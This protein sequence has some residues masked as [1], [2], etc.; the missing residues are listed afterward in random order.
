[1][2]ELSTDEQ[3]RDSVVIK[4]DDVNNE[5]ISPVR[6]KKEGK[7]PE[8]VNVEDGTQAKTIP[9]KTD[10]K[11]KTFN[12]ATER[13][14]KPVENTAVEKKI[15]SS[16]PDKPANVSKDVE[17]AKEC[18]KSSVKS[19]SEQGMQVKNKTTTEKEA[20]C[21]VKKNLINVVDDAV[22][23]TVKN[24]STQKKVVSEKKGVTE[25]GEV[26]KL[27]VENIKPAGISAPSSETKLKLGKGS[28]T[29]KSAEPK[30]G[31]TSVMR[32]KPLIIG[33]ENDQA[34][35]EKSQ[36]TANI[37]HV[38][39]KV[40]QDL[41]DTE[42]EKKCAEN[43]FE[44]NKLDTAVDED[45]HSGNEKKS[46]FSLDH[47][48]GRLI[49]ELPGATAASPS[50][51][52][53]SIE[54]KN[55]NVEKSVRNAENKKTSA[56][57]STRAEMETEIGNDPAE[58][59]LGSTEVSGEPKVAGEGQELG[60]SVCAVGR[61]VTASSSRNAI[62]L[63][64]SKKLGTWQKSD[65]ANQM[66]ETVEPKTDVK[67]LNKKLEDSSKPSTFR[68][69]AK[70]QGRAKNIGEDNLI[71]VSTI[72]RQNCDDSSVKNQLRDRDLARA[73]KKE[74]S[75]DKLQ[76]TLKSLRT[77]AANPTAK[78]SGSRRVI[79]KPRGK[80]K[81][82]V[83]SRTRRSHIATPNAVQ[84]SSS[85]DIHLTTPKVSS[86]SRM[87]RKMGKR[88]STGTCIRESEKDRRKKR[89]KVEERKNDLQHLQASNSNLRRRLKNVKSKLFS[90][91]KSF[92]A[93]KS[94]RQEEKLQRSKKRT[95]AISK[96]TEL[97]MAGR[98]INFNKKSKRQH[99]SRRNDKVAG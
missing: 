11:T 24:P 41:E 12:N 33:S 99:V 26:A 32:D 81:G 27:T 86:A 76:P 71:K 39:S 50:I 70:E 58:E 7:C 74:E 45:P 47:E 49:K 89:R 83:G 30:S 13:E 4:V 53:Q 68:D 1:M 6:G 31:W 94:A 40:Q 75:E 78:L 20:P 46:H 61:Q 57:E 18:K 10:Q 85:G 66:E 17:A 9:K 15:I 28:Y 44:M 98:S 56:K 5:C 22:R 63:E 25:D 80:A 52:P 14:N 42:S 96:Q 67:R 73:H 59:N 19:E 87:I 21:D 29:V 3:A 35:S 60:K 2:T 23:L 34:S 64:V 37:N 82:K 79:A 36:E 77:K 54:T 91:T 62:T 88:G 16:V 95:K 69:A 38:S 65:D 97:R 92:R 84:V 93:Y 43:S 8:S 55:I 48:Q 72:D 51:G 90:E